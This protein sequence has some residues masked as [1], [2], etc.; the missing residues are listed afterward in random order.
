LREHLA[1]DNLGQ[2]KGTESRTDGEPMTAIETSMPHVLAIV[3][4]AAANGER[5]PTNPE[6]ATR[7]QDQGIALRPSSIP[8]VLREL[9]RAGQIVTYVYGKNY[10]AIK[11]C[12][13]PQAGKSTAPPAHDSPPYII[14][15][16]NE[17]N[18]RDSKRRPQRRYSYT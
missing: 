6:I 3:E 4:K 17:R 2:D 18:K 11:I 10:R 1:V 13:G 8:N 15:D 16:A 5:C 14:I 12:I 7:L 9:T